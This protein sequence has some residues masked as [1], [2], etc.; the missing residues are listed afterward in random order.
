MM[1][2]QFPHQYKFFPTRL[3]LEKQIRSDHVL[4]KISERVD[5]GFIREE[6]KET[7]GVNGNVSVPRPVI[8]GTD[9]II[10]VPNFGK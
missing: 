9:L 4:R 10:A 7:Y 1:G 3:N 2:R 6:I 5:F 8:K